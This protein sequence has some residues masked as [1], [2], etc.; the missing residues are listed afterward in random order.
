MRV[1]FFLRKKLLPK[2]S[3]LKIKV[4]EGNFLKI[5]HFKINYKDLQKKEKEKKRQLFT[6]RT[7]SL[8]A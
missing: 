7:A 4:G 8:I 1:F 2:F 3:L 6:S 5:L